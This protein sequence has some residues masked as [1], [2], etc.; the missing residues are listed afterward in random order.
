MQKIETTMRVDAIVIRCIS[1]KIGK[2]GQSE[3]DRLSQYNADPDEKDYE[4]IEYVFS[5]CKQD[6]DDMESFLIEYYKDNPKCDNKKGGKVSNNDKMAGDAEVYHVYV[7]WKEKKQ[8]KEI[9]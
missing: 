2:T 7:V 6:V 9:K 4:Y 8:R 5:G 3:D 1:F